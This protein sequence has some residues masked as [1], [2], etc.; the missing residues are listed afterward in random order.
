[1]HNHAHIVH[2]DIKPDNLLVSKDDTLKVS[3]F[4]IS[5]VFEHGKEDE[6]RDT[7][8]TKLF[9]APETFVK[10]PFRGMPVDIWA[11]GAT[12]YYMLIGVPPFKSSNL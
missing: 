4:G 7:K 2:R 9:M 5:H 11:M 10:G 6:L 12:L 1:M 3:D 8:G